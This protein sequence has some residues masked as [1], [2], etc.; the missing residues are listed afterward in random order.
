MHRKAFVPA[1]GRKITEIN[2]GWSLLESA[3]SENQQVLNEELKNLTKLEQVTENI[4]YFSLCNRKR[5]N[6]T[7]RPKCRRSGS[8]AQRARS[9]RWTTTVTSWPSK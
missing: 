6:S 4:I 9:I 7:K 3:E 2:K 8:R 5:F 1:E